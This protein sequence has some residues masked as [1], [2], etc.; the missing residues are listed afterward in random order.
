MKLLLAVVFS[1]VL[2]RQ[3]RHGIQGAFEAVHGKVAT[4][5]EVDHKFTKVVVIF[6]W[7]ANHGRVFEWHKCLTNGKNGPFCRAGVFLVQ[8]CV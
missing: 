3:N 8:G 2:D 1:L 5:A 6:H 7:T 4:G